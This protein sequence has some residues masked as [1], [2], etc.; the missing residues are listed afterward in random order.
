M[1]GT[2]AQFQDDFCAVLFGAQAAGER[3]A[4]LTSQRGFAVYR[5]TVVKGCIDALEANFP[6][7]VSLVGQQWFRGVA[8]AYVQTHALADARLV[9]YGERFAAFL[10]GLESVHALPYLADVARLDYLWI[11][12]HTAA[13]DTLVDL[14]ALAAFVPDALERARLRPHSA[15]RWIWFAEHPAFSIWRAN[16]EAAAIPDDL[17]WQAQGAL[18]TRPDGAVRW[19]SIPA[20]AHA[21]I[22]ACAKGETF[23]AAVQQV[24]QAQPNAD[25]P[26]LIGECIAAGAF[27]A[28][29]R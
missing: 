21:F 23:E 17:A 15:A 16:R 14:P 5:N 9:Y 29:E 12:A 24:W 10:G 22:E 8:A 2:L 19:R 25:L 1:T 26:A 28:I 4:Y 11:E 3:L 13:D 27:A 6:A 7:V 18:L 20:G